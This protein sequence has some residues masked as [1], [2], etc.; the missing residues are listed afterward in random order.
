M[1]TVNWVS[2]GV[3]AALAAA[4]IILRIY[5]KRKSDEYDGLGGIIKR[6]KP[7]AAI[8]AETQKTDENPS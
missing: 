2:I 1:T 6:R 7:P 8:P 4:Y 5:V 3:T